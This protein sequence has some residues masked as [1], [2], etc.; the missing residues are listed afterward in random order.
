[1]ATQIEVHRG[2][3][4]GGCIT[5]IWTEKTRILIDFGEELPGSRQDMPFEFH[6]GSR[7]VN[8]VLF[9]HYHGDHIGRF[10]EASQHADVYMSELSREVLANIHGYL[11]EKLPKLADF[12]PEKADELREE[13]KKHEQALGI[14]HGE[15]VHTFQPHEK[16]TIEIGDIC[17]TPFRVDHSAADACMFLIETPDKRILHT[18]D[19]RGHGIH[20]QEG[21]NIRETVQS[22]AAE[23]G[24]DALI[25]EG[26]M[27]S[28]QDEKPYSEADLRGD[29]DRLFAEHR[30]VFLIVS[31]TN[32]D[33][34]STF[35]Q[36]AK[37]KGISMYA[38]SLYMERQ[39]KRLGKY[40]HAH[41]KEPKRPDMSDIER[42][43][44]WDKA[45]CEAMREDGFVA[46]IKANEVCQ[47]LVEQ[48]TDCKPVVAY[49]MWQGYYQRKLDG[50]LCDFVDT[51]KEK[52]IPVYPLTDRTYG[53]LHTSGHASPALIAEVI[54]AAAPK[55]LYPIHTED[56]WEFLRLDIPE[57]LKDHLQDK[58]IQ[59]GEKAGYSQE[60]DHRCL[61]ETAL[62]KF[63][64]G[65][66]YHIFVQLV[67]KHP[68]LAFC[69]RGNSDDAAI[70]YYQNHAA[71]H[72]T[73]AGS[74]KFNFNHAR[75]M[76]DWRAQ[77]EKLE[78]A[79]YSF[80]NK[81]TP[82]LKNGSYTIGDVSMSKGRAGQ[83]TLE[84]LEQLYT[85]SIRVMI[86]SFFDAKKKG[87]YDRFREEYSPKRERRVST[88]G[89][90]EKPV[91]QQLFLHPEF[92]KLR[93]GYFI[94]DLEFVQPYGRLLRCE[95]QPDMLAI[96]FDAD[97][98]P[99]RL[100]FVE[101]KSKPETLKGE[102]G[103]EKHIRGM[104]HYL[105]QLLPV[106][107]RDAYEILEQYRR[108]GLLA[109]PE[110]T[111]QREDFES[112]PKEVLLIFTGQDTINALGKEVGES[113]PRFLRDMGYT[114]LAL[115]EK[116]LSEM[117]VYHKDC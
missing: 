116:P 44:T 95:N 104:E 103:L 39:I 82:E 19:F 77:R 24:I 90:A 117:E 56:A 33:S 107:S 7:P 92:N 62:T 91:Q 42:V 48:F 112:L 47:E 26:T 20:G 86:N 108:L 96:R 57:Q 22:M 28:R 46:V 78:A 63:L 84:Q 85:D 68:E 54:N 72:I 18:G 58:M 89:L 110:G 88:Q 106:R 109:V 101:V 25:I 98:K 43:R 9:T 52:E 65:K 41:D 97:G 32:L 37:D 79:G 38:H 8:A 59:A 61:S 23:K 50:A 17:V 31:S 99:E 30:C 66:P 49:S 87:E 6:W 21:E 16:Q 13:A 76:P 14:L 5:E 73:K 45:Q 27:M 3:Q 35:Y 93:D 51:C 74:V 60:N 75:Y 80:Q 36:A 115:D 81:Q 111:F 67:K 70:V 83:L 4:I 15:R 114:A 53:P 1:M 55:E 94:Y 2:D 12:Q 113:E 34:I 102:S 11:A 40:A 69:F 10:A 29:A 64:P 100:V 71:F 105:P